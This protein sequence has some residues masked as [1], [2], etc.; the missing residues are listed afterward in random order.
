MGKSLRVIIYRKSHFILEP[1]AV[2][3]KD[4]IR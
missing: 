2:T 3:D 1:T 4:H